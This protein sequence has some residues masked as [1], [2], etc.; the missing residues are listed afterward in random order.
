MSSHR[1]RIVEEVPNQKTLSNTN[2]AKV[3]IHCEE[4]ERSDSIAWS[5]ECDRVAER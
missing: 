4:L 3:E 1:Y 5:K 2:E